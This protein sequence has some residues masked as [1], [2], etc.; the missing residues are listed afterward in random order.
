MITR[1]AA[2]LE[3][4]LLALLPRAWTAMLMTDRLIPRA[5]SERLSIQPRAVTSDVP[6]REPVRHTVVTPPLE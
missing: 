3:H 4:R 6:D 5:S 2:R 1:L